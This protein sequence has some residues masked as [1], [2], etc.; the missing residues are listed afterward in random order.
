M[1]FRVVWMW[2]GYR[3]MIRVWM[4]RQNWNWR[5]VWVWWQDWSRWVMRVNNGSR[6]MRDH[7]WMWWSGEDFEAIFVRRWNGGVDRAMVSWVIDR[8]RVRVVDRWVSNGVIH[9]WRWQGV[10]RWWRWE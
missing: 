5:V 7:R 2:N 10:F 3:W 8:W 1:W 6:V 4:L 9:R